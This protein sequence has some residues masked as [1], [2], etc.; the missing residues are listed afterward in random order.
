MT[1]DFHDLMDELD[2][3][4]ALLSQL[5]YEQAT[6]QEKIW[7]AGVTGLIGGFVIALILTQVVDWCA[8]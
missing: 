3:N 7:F 4:T 8:V 5:R 1:N 2:S 6:Y